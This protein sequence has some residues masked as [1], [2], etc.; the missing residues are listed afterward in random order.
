MGFEMTILSSVSLVALQAALI[1]FIHQRLLPIGVR[2]T[3]LTLVEHCAA[4]MVVAMS[5]AI[6]LALGLVLEGIAPRWLLAGVSMGWISHVVGAIVDGVLHLSDAERELRELQSERKWAAAWERP[7]LQHRRKKGA[8]R[9][10][11]D[12]QSEQKNAADLELEDLRS[13]PKEDAESARR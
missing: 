11:W 10:P 7:D 3:R 12:L 1:I 2:I 9:E 13:E 6:L 5:V 4:T 8:E